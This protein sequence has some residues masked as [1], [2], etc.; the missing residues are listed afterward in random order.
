MTWWF[1]DR[2]VDTSVLVRLA[3]TECQIGSLSRPQIF[4]CLLF[5]LPNTPRVF[6]SFSFSFYCH[7]W[8]WLASPSA[9]TPLYNLFPPQLNSQSLSRE[10][11]WV[12]SGDD[13]W[14]SIFAPAE[15]F[16]RQLKPNSTRNVAIL[17]RFPGITSQILCASRGI[18]IGRFSRYS[19]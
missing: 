10:R 12:I 15:D 13:M 16:S 5:A 6:F 11:V 17:W 7:F 9:S 4:F 8:R 14:Q 18:Y 3:F 1:A 2:P 19:S